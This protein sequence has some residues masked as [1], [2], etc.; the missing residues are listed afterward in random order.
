MAINT[1]YREI[2]EEFAELFVYYVDYYAQYYTNDKVNK[3]TLSN[4][5]LLASLKVSV[6]DYDLLITIN[7]YYQFVESGR[8]KFAKRVPIS[9][10]IKWIKKKKIQG[11]NKKGQFISVNKLAF[12]IQAGI[13]YSGIA[14]R[15][16]VSDAFVKAQQELDKFIDKRLDKLLNTMLDKLLTGEN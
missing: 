14:P 7:S 12:A 5:D 2:L 13:Y 11:R 16:F 8:E 15:P 1:S 3:D 4:S 9:A 6:T 10:L